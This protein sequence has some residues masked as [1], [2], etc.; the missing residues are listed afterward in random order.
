MTRDTRALLAIKLV[1]TVA[2]AF[3][4]GCILAVP[5]LAWFGLLVPAT[6]L[7]GVVLVEV[8]ILVFNDW[9]CR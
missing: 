5:V 1:H 3:F 7:C 8:V 6:V 9:H 4:A 2:W